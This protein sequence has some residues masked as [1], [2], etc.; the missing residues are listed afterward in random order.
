MLWPAVDPDN[1]VF[2]S[3]DG[4]S[5]LCPFTQTWNTKPR[6]PWHHYSSSVCCLSLLI[7]H[8]FFSI[9]SCHPFLPLFLQNMTLLAITLNSD[10]SLRLFVCPVSLVSTTF[11]RCIC[12]VYFSVHAVL[13]SWPIFDLIRLGRV[14]VCYSHKRAL[15]AVFCGWTVFDLGCECWRTWANIRRW[16][17]KLSR[18]T[19]IYWH[20]TKYVWRF[21]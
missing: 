17:H 13:W 10:I 3:T 2:M 12:N 15:N 18:F 7:F 11:P 5:T 6:L 8:P 20:L 19:V 4:V 9:S 1:H 21:F 14:C 16:S